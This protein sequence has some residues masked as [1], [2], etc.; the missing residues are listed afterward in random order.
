MTLDLD[1]SS[2]ALACHDK[3][4]VRIVSSLLYFT[5][6]P[7]PRLRWYATRGVTSYSSLTCER[8][9]GRSG[10]PNEGEGGGV[11]G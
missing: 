5:H 1:A 8:L 2:F 3:Y 9:D 11:T 7:V 6:E 4:C 10:R